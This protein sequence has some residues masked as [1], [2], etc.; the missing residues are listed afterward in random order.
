MALNANEPLSPEELA[1]LKTAA[2]T[3][4]MVDQITVVDEPE[5]PEG[6]AAV[7]YV[8]SHHW[9]PA[10]YRT[11]PLKKVE[12]LS[13]TL[14]DPRAEIVK[15]KKALMLLGH[16]GSIEVQRSLHR[17]RPFRKRSASE[18]RSERRLLNPSA[19]DGIIGRNSSR[20]KCGSQQSRPQRTVSMRQWKEVEVL[21]WRLKLSFSE[22][23]SFWFLCSLI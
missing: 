17:S 1:T 3:S 14:F 16:R 15:K 7:E 22:K 9:L 8:N 5:S 11:L 23:V 18:R 21:L 4:A 13:K 12:A 2:K 19:L 20:H 6:K 10:N